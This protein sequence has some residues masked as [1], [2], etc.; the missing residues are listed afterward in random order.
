M[1][2]TEKTDIHSIYRDSPYR[3]FP[4]PFLSQTLLT[5]C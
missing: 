5:T 4:T 2:T 1:D 3:Q